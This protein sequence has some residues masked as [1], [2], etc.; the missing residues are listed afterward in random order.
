MTGSPGIDQTAALG[1]VSDFLK[2]QQENLQ[3]GVQPVVPDFPLNSTGHT[4][5]Y[6]YVD[7]KRI[8][9]T[10]AADEA[11]TRPVAVRCVDLDETRCAVP[12][13]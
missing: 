7:A 3:K 4:K 13:I 10:V 5:K 9:D 8:N 1:T 2:E 11:A 12:D 6:H